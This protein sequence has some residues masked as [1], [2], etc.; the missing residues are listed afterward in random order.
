MRS[1]E[2]RFRIMEKKF[3]FHSSL[4]CFGRAVR[5]QK[6]GRAMKAKYFRRLVDKEDYARKD[7]MRLT[8]H[9]MQMT[10]KATT[11]EDAKLQGKKAS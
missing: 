7:I 4:I 1:V 10:E 3:P 8:D 6:F 2:A 5:G 9:F 11:F